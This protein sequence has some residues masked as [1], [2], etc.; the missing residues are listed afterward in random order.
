MFPAN[1]FY[2]FSKEWNTNSIKDM[3]ISA[4]ESAEKNTQFLFLTDEERC[5]FLFMYNNMSV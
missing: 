5:D 3:Y 4:I 2:E 1:I